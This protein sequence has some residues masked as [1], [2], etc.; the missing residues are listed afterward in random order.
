VRRGQAE[1][2]KVV[3]QELARAVQVLHPLGGLMLLPRDPD[4]IRVM[5]LGELSMCPEYVRRCGRQVQPELM[6]G[7]TAALAPVRAGSPAALISC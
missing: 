3:Q 4:A 1:F 5:A 7:A 2:V 6:Q